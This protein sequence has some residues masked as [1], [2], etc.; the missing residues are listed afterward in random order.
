MRIF[1]FLGLVYFS[2]NAISLEDLFRQQFIPLK[3]LCAQG[4]EDLVQRY[5]KKY[6]ELKKRVNDL[7]HETNGVI[8]VTTDH[9]L[10]EKDYNKFFFHEVMEITPRIIDVLDG[11]ITV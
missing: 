11:C 4:K 8:A 5:I 3:E 10:A 9:A 1:F 7:S 2:L 6:E